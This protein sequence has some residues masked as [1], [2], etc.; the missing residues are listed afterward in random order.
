MAVE[1]NWNCRTVDV[2]PTEGEETNVVYNVHWAVTG[3]SDELD[4]Q[5]EPYQSNS[6]GT[7]TIINDPES[8]FIPFDE[9]TNEIIVAWVQSTMG[10]ELVS[11]IEGVLLQE[12]EA[13]INP[14]SV[15][16]TII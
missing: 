11:N 7:Q 5:D 16:K 3:T 12:I 15:T 2:R 9:L 10:D 8:E 4:P 14:T 6:V 13:K 1:Y